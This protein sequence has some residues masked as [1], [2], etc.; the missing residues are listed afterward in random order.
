MKKKDWTLTL[1]LTNIFFVFLGIGLVIPVLP[2]IMNELGISGTVVGY[3][4][5]AFALAQLIFSPLA[6]K[7]VDKYGRKRMIVIGLFIFSFSEFLFGLGK[8][9]EVL[10]ASRILGGISAAFIMPAVTAFIAD[11]TTLKTRPKALGYMSAMI[12]TGFIIGPGI[13]GFLAGIG[14]RVPFF[15]AAACGLIVA[16]V[17][18]LSLK[19][20][21]SKTDDMADMTEELGK[22]GLRKVFMPMFFIAFI[23]I[24]ISTFGLAAFDSFFSL[25]TDHK[26]G[27]TPSDIAIAITGGAIIG[28]IFQV[29]LFDWLTKLIG[30]INI[31]RWSLAISAMLVFA[32]TLANSYWQV[33]AVTFT[34][35]IGFDLIR[36]A[37]TNYLSKIAG[38]EQGFVG[39]MN[40]FFT[41]LANVFGPVVGGVLFD[42]DINYPFVFSSIVIV[43][44]LLITIFWKKPDIKID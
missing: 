21:K 40:S 32:M 36:P 42:I 19:E 20:P 30:E 1:L 26:H 4:T 3:L 14:T 38:N 22:S 29:V 7:A 33:M 6:G 5:A 23:V 37:V 12:S 18:I 41:S 25:Y 13:G 35:F 44:C 10:F 2:T 31:I 34:V 43:V 39:G 8:T 16:F 24:L 28:A 27:F 17:S 9:I 11:I 15:S